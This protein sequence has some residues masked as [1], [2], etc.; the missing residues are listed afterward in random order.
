M[1]RPCAS[2]VTV[3]TRPAGVVVVIVLALCVN[4]L[5]YVRPLITSTFV[6][7]VRLKGSVGFDS[8]AVRVVVSVEVRLLGSRTDR[9][10]RIGACMPKR[11]SG[12]SIVVVT[13]PSGPVTVVVPSCPINVV[14]SNPLG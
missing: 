1:T 2:S 3:L 10:D 9:L 8:A 5:V 7:L 13:V 4:V 14:V 6:W 11:G 12:P